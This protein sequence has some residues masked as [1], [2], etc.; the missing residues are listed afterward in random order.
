MEGTPKKP[1]CFLSS[2]LILSTTDGISCS[3]G[4]QTFDKNLKAKVLTM[5]LNSFIL[6]R[7][8]LGN[9]KYRH[10]HFFLNL[11]SHI[12]SCHLEIF[13]K[14]NQNFQH[15]V[16][17]L[18]HL[19]VGWSINVGLVQRS[20]LK[21]T[22]ILWWLGAEENGLGIRLKFMILIRKSLLSL[23]VDLVFQIEHIQLWL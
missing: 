13:Q 22:S 18:S 9:R 5:I 15:Q 20:A 19:N 14:H 4:E 11:Y 10:R 7:N 1:S 3:Q 12:K 21:E 23:L 2:D 16:T 17:L 8:E 6:H